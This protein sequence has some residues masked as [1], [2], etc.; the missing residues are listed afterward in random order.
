MPNFDKTG[1][2]GQGPKTGNQKGKCDGIVLQQGPPAGRGQGNG[3]RGRGGRGM[4]Q[5]QGR[6]NMFSRMINK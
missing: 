5:A 4:G 6:K 3:P 2:N 1:P